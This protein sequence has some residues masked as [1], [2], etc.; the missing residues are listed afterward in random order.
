M[1]VYTFFSLEKDIK[2]ELGN[3]KEFD[4]I[5]IYLFI[6]KVAQIYTYIHIHTY[7]HTPLYMC[8]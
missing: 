3:Y 6:N 5:N 1:C 8:V 4:V 7:M 2:D